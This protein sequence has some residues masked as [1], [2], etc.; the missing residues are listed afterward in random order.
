MSR[1]AWI[2]TAWGRPFESLMLWLEE[3]GKHAHIIDLKPVILLLQTKG[4]EKDFTSLA[5]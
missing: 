3:G 2:V 4:K 5:K 1:L